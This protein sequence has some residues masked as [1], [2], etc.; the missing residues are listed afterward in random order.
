MGAD[1]LEAA[2]GVA[3]GQGVALGGR[4]LGVVLG[5]GGLN[6][7][8][9]LNPGAGQRQVVEEVARERVARLREQLA[10]TVPNLNAAGLQSVRQTLAGA[11]QTVLDRVGGRGRGV[12]SHRNAPITENEPERRDIAAWV[13]NS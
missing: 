2:V 8:A 1:P 3:L 7:D 9:K 11:G 13:K 6:L 10:K 12:R 5:H 4:D